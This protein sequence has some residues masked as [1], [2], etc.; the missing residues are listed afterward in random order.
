M[1]ALDRYAA[2]LRIEHEPWRDDLGSISTTFTRPALIAGQ[3]RATAYSRLIAG[4][5]PLPRRHA[6]DQALIPP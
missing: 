4:N 2:D 5:D 6:G 1:S 3:R